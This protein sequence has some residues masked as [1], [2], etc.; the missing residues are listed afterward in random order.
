MAKLPSL[1]SLLPDNFPE[2]K[3]WIKALLVP[4]NKFFTEVVDALNKKLNIT[5]NL[6]GEVIEFTVDGNYPKELAWPRKQKPRIG[7]IGKVS[8]ADGS[9]VSLSAGISPVWIY[10]Q[11]GL[12][13]ISDIVGLDDSASKKYVIT[14]VFLVN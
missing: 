14:M 9:D 7:W 10:T 3:G 6:D 2:Q 4:L 5:D 8:R 12:I 11:D 1:K 13:S